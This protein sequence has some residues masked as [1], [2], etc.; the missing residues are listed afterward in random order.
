MQSGG[1]QAEWWPASPSCGWGTSSLAPARP[2]D[3]SSP[4]SPTSSPSSPSSHLRAPSSP[5]WP[6][7]EFRALDQSWQRWVWMP[8]PET[9][10]GEAR[11][12]KSWLRWNRSDLLP[13]T[14]FMSFGSWLAKTMHIYQFVV[15]YWHAKRQ[16][17]KR[18]LSG[19]MVQSG[20]M[21]QSLLHLGPWDFFITRV[22]NFDCPDSLLD[23]PSYVWKPNF[24]WKVFRIYFL[25]WHSSLY[26]DD[27]LDAHRYFNSFLLDS[28]KSVSQSSFNE[29]WFLLL[30]FLIDN[31]ICI[32]S[33]A[34]HST[35]LTI[36]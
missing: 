12:G 32:W 6:S 27:W 26:F 20:I 19:K 22:D 9:G 16:A 7:S 3:T 5:S 30:Q 1:C 21:N 17:G 34:Q 35:V 36:S 4:S 24:G 31:W 10:W 2:P 11:L 23:W 33:K 18:M 28:T 25:F 14:F 15:P 29:A 13:D 8:P